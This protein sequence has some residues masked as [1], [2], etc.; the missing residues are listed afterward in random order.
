LVQAI[1]ALLEL[2]PRE[3][4]ELLAMSA[5]DLEKTLNPPKLR[6]GH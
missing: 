3:L 5:E 4:E 2:D 6:M 1:S